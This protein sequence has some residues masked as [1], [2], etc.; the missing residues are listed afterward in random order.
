ML[1]ACIRGKRT[2]F[3]TGIR[4]HS[5][6]P[7]DCLRTLV[8]GAVLE[9]RSV[10]RNRT[11]QHDCFSY[12]RLYATRN[13]L[14]CNYRCV[15]TLERAN[16]V[17]GP[18]MEADCLHRKDQLFDVPHSHPRICG[19]RTAVESAHLNVQI[20]DSARRSGSFMHYAPR[21]TLLEVFRESYS[22]YQRSPFLCSRPPLCSLRTCRSIRW[23][24]TPS[25]RMGPDSY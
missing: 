3:E 19:S 9:M 8:P 10:R 14:C 1:C 4:A 24:L 6:R 17:C 7:N 23:R 13:L 5:S 18:R 21:S 12:L 11:A 15:R 2:D 22:C 25:G 20:P 16:L